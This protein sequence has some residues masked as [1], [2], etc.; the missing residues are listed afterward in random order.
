MNKPDIAR[1]S[2]LAA[3]A[4]NICVIGTVPPV[5]QKY[6]ITSEYTTN[7]DL[8]VINVRDSATILAA[9]SCIINDCSIVICEY[10]DK[11]VIAKVQ[12]YL[13]ESSSHFQYSRQMLVDA[14]RE[15]SLLVRYSA[16]KDVLR[17]TD[18]ISII[19]VLRNGGPVYNY[20]Y[21]NAPELN[22]RRHVTHN[23]EIVSKT[24]D[25][26]RSL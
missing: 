9:L 22:I 14:I 1:L 7:S 8:V 26:R 13:D 15:Q 11:N 23:Q 5:L 2:R 24:D 6:S 4:T 16:K 21:V 25:L 10:T 20:R 17:R 18:P 19:L 3:T 12:Q